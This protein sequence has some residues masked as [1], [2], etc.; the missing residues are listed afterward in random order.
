MTG[1]VDQRTWSKFVAMTHTPT[2]AERHNIL[3]AGPALMNAELHNQV[4]TGS[5]SG[6]DRRCI[7]GPAICVSKRTNSLV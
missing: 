7:T 2:R 3:V 4:P 1:E 6:L 5:A